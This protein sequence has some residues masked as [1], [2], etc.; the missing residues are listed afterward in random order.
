MIVFLDFDGVTHP[1][2]GSTPFRPDCLEALSCATS[3]LNTHIVITSSW[4]L[5][6]NLD[7]LKLLLGDELG[8][9]VIDVTPELDQDPFLHWPRAREVLKWLIQNRMHD[10]PWVAIDDEEGNYPAGYSYITDRQTGFTNR[11]IPLLLEHAKQSIESKPL[12]DVL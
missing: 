6:Y 3:E 5:E 7:E 1:V 8:S 11:D 2:S 12:I 9:R 4:R 10:K